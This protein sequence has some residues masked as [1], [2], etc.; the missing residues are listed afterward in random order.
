[1]ATA[2]IFACTVKKTVLTTAVVER[3]EVENAITGIGE[4][5]PEFEATISRPVNASVEKVSY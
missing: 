3:G 5:L 1:M 2:G 4:V